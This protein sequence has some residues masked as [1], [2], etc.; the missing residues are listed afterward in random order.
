MEVRGNGRSAV[1]SAAILAAIFQ[2]YTL[3][4]FEGVELWAKA[5]MYAEKLLVHDRG[6]WQRTECFHTCVVDLLRVFV[7]AFELE[8]EVIGQM[9][10]FMVPSQQP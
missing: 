9:A 8:G 2:T 4:V 7:L 5:T 6:Q 3:E 10:T 1:V